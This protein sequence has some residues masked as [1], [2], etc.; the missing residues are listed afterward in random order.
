MAFVAFADNRSRRH[1]ARFERVHESL[2]FGV[3]EHC[4]HR[5]H[6]FR[7]KRAEYLL[8]ERNARRMI[9]Q[10]IRIQ[11]RCAC[12]ICKNESVCRSAVM[13]GG[14]EPLIM[15]ASC[16]TGCN[17]NC[18]CT[19]YQIF[20]RFHILQHCASSFTIFVQNQLNRRCKVNNRNFT[21]HD[22][23]TQHAHNLCAGIISC[24]VHPFARRT[25]AM[26]C[27]H[28][29][30]RRF[31]KHHA[32]LVEPF[33]CAGP[34]GHQLFQK[35]RFI[36]VMASAQCIQIMDRRGIVRFIGCLYAALSHHCVGVAHAKLRYDHNVCP[37]VMRLNR[38]RSACAAAANDE[39]VNIICHIFKV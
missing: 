29:S 21:V 8:R 38:R 11:K 32:K 31:I 6:L 3:N 28:R 27:D 18:L 7:H 22:F 23:V 15:Q 13:V 1:I 37:C 30:V 36:C 12:T 17:D 24:C 25:A 4:S 34:F 20:A 5:A 39:Y 10:G 2:P 16:P 14:W 26:R 33:Y 35:L 9:L 19:R